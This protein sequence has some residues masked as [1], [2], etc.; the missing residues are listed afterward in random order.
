MGTGFAAGCGEEGRCF[1]PLGDGGRFRGLGL[2]VE[3]EGGL[4]AVVAGDGEGEGDR[5]RPGRLEGE[6]GLFPAGEGGRLCFSGFCVFSGAPS[7]EAVEGGPPFCRSML[8]LR[9]GPLG[10]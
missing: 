6:G 1:I 9:R 10:G 2:A 4:L 8:R 3:G 5:R 7:E